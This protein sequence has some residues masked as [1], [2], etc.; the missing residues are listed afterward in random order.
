MKKGPLIVSV[1]LSFWLIALAIKFSLFYSP[2]HLAVIASLV[3]LIIGSGII[4]QNSPKGEAAPLLTAYASYGILLLMGYSVATYNSP[5]PS[6]AS[7]FLLAS[8]FL[9]ILSGVWNVIK[10]LGIKEILPQIAYL[11]ALLL[12]LW[13]LDIRIVTGIFSL[14]AALVISRS[15]LLYTSPSPRD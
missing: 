15:C 11:I 14:S 12:G 8:S 4:Y 2:L 5:Q 13:G 7:E 9:P 10:G 6:I 3:V 1:L